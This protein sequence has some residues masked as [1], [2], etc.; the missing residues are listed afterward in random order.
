VGPLQAGMRAPAKGS[1]RLGVRREGLTACVFCVTIGDMKDEGVRSAKRP[2]RMVARADAALATANRVLDVALE[3]FTE[4]PYED[5]SVEEIA[6]RAEVTKRTVLRRFGSKEALFLAA[7]ERGGREEMRARDAAPVGDVAGA[8]ANVVAHYERWGANR[9]RL[10]SQEDRIAVVAEDVEIG[11]RY[12]WSWVER[13]FAPLIDG[14]TGAARKRRIAALVMLTDVYTWK[15]LR[16]D[17]GLSQAETER[18][19]VELI[20][21][22]EGE[23]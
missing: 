13:T 15:L 20:H 7:M 1:A 12:H 4:R 10:L 23:S 6:Q 14:L 18:T 19:V 16:R 9:L 5:V 2:Y 8:V 17:L 3:L 22:L 21:K 11:R